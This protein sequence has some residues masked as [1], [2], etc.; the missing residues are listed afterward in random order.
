MPVG[1]SVSNAYSIV[2]SP[3]APLCHRHDERA[4]LNSGGVRFRLD[5]VSPITLAHS[6]GLPDLAIFHA[7]DSGLILG[8]DT[9]VV[10]AALSVTNT[11]VLA[12]DFDV[13]RVSVTLL[14]RLP[15]DY[16]M[17]SAGATIGY[18]CGP[19][20]VTGA[21]PKDVRTL[22]SGR[23]AAADELLTSCLLLRLWAHPVRPEVIA[24]TPLEEILG[25]VRAGVFD[26]GV[27]AP[28]GR[29]LHGDHRLH[30]ALDLGEAW[31]GRTGLP[32]PLCVT[33]ARRS[34]DTDAL[35]SVIEESVRYSFDHEQARLAYIAST[36]GRLDPDGQRRHFDLY[37]RSTPLRL[38]EQH[39]TAIET[40]LSAAAAAGLAG[41]P[42]ALR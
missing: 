20:L 42:P 25:G 33:V 5:R 1:V 30:V 41:D 13:A 7:W 31:E 36:A 26:G 23:I 14:G 17:L 19:I 34:L 4:A 2:L 27:L 6:Y 38:T 18:G 8:P 9:D 12:G 39:H 11:G 22:R 35:T 10:H 3:H 24:P 29:F 16:V 40:L 28:E 37:R 15:S 32:T 21:P